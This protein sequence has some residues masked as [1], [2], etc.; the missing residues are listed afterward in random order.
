MHHKLRFIQYP[1]AQVGNNHDAMLQCH[2]ESS[3][4]DS[5]RMVRL[6]VEGWFCHQ[7]DCLPLDFLGSDIWIVLRSVPSGGRV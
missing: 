6:Q 1:L 3:D 4:T 5:V 2:P 7:F